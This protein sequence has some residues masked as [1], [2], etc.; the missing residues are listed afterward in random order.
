MCT[1][2]RLLWLAAAL[3]LL[4]AAVAEDEVGE[5][6]GEEGGEES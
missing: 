3:L 5:L 6:D 2:A 1:M 4:G